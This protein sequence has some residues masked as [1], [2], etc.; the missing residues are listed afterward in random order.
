MLWFCLQTAVLLLRRLVVCRSQ[1]MTGTLSLPILTS[2]SQR[3]TVTKIMSWQGAT[4]KALVVGAVGW[5]ITWLRLVFGT[6]RYFI[7]IWIMAMRSWGLGHF[8]LIQ[9]ENMYWWPTMHQALCWSLVIW[10]WS[11]SIR[12]AQ[13]IGAWP[14]MMIDYEVIIQ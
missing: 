5:F 13:S 8:F 3:F 6:N 1:W 11:L 9:P 12:N 7:S 14:E 2:T 10:W 4:W